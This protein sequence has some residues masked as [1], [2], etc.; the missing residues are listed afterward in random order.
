MRV[1]EKGPESLLISA[2]GKYLGLV[3]I[4]RPNKIS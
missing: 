1:R 4:T 3:L 2:E